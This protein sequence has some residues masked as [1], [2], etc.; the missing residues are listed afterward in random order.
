METI[1]KL[2]VSLF[3]FAAL[4]GQEA[5]KTK[6]VKLTIGPAAQ[7]D[8]NAHAFLDLLEKAIQAKNLTC[9]PRISVDVVEKQGKKGT[10]KVLD[11]TLS[12]GDRD[13]HPKL[14]TTALPARPPAAS[15]SKEEKEA[16]IQTINDFADK[17][18]RLLVC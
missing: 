9:D 4:P 16:Y 17:I 18:T 8:P 14:I 6:P 12:K 11:F 5:Q 2:A 10:Y 13:P 1:L 15:A 7:A 3:L